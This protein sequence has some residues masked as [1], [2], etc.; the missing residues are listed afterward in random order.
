M[1]VAKNIPTGEATKRE[2]ALKSEI[3]ERQSNEAMSRDKLWEEVE[4]LMNRVPGK[5]SQWRSE[6]IGEFKK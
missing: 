5:N 4:D 3:E 2:K 6:K 1:V